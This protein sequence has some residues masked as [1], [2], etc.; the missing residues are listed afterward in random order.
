MGKWV[1]INNEK[2]LGLLPL[3][4]AELETK[5]P[6]RFSNAW[7]VPPMCLL[8][9]SMFGPHMGEQALKHWESSFSPSALPGWYKQN[10]LAGNLLR[11]IIKPKFCI[12]KV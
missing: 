5:V 1:G 8:C 9:C 2:A 10:E 11:K 7:L 6:S 12:R 3:L 4:K